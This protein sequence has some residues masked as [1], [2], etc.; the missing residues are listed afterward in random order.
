M[1]TK[2]DYQGREE[3]AVRIRPRA[4][5]AAFL[6]VRWRGWQAVDRFD[7]R[8]EHAPLP[9][10]RGCIRIVSGVLT[11]RRCGGGRVEIKPER[12]LFCF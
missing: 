11:T 12:C 7:E 1:T 10:H 9:Y 5:G 2:D 3:E 6:G 4:S 8:D